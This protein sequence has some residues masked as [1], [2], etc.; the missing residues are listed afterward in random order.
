MD[1]DM[2]IYLRTTKVRAFALIS[3]HLLVSLPTPST[4]FVGLNSCPQQRDHCWSR[5]VRQKIYQFLLCSCSQILCGLLLTKIPG[6]SLEFISTDLFPGVSRIFPVRF[7]DVHHHLSGPQ[8]ALVSQS[9][10][11]MSVWLVS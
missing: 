3:T 6:C 5:K 10:L 11:S 9:K 4:T 2:G 1:L 7:W 8:S